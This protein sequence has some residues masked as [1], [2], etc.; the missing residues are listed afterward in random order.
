MTTACVQDRHTGLESYGFPTEATRPVLAC[1]ASTLSFA[2]RS[3]PVIRLALGAQ[4][5]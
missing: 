5:P 4:G 3:Q 1:I 2:W